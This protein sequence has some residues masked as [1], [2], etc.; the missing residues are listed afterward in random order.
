MAQADSTTVATTSVDSASEDTNA[1]LTEK[2]PTNT[3]SKHLTEREYTLSLFILGFGVVVIL[4][5]FFVGHRDTV[6]YDYIF[7]LT[8]VTLVITSSLFLVIA[9][10][11]SEQIAP[12][13]GL[14]GTI[15]GY[16]LGKASTDSDRSKK[17][18]ESK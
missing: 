13:I 12:V 8:A 4:I 5:I 3:R 2:Q 10:Y 16:L 7:K 1:P 6:S 17:N 9:G 18:N 11:S 15:S 14:L